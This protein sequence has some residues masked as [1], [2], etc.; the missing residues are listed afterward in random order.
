MK[1][2]IIILAMC[3]CSLA[4]GQQKNAK[5]QNAVVAEA[6]SRQAFVFKAQRV[7]PMPDAEQTVQDM[8]PGRGDI[9]QLNGNYGL[10]LQNDTLDVNLPYFG[11]AFMYSRGE[12][13]DGGIKF[14]STRYSFEQNKV[15]KGYE[16]VL[17]PQD[18]TDIRNITISVSE[19]GYATVSVTSIRKAPIRYTGMLTPIK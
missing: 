13:L 15:K 18:H 11:R 8:F 17:K 2:V 3:C 4:F 1:Y 14:V 10:R 16:L 19:D 5:A 12:E 6:I 7:Q 9:F